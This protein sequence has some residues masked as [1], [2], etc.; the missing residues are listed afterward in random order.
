MKILSPPVGA[1]DFG[2]ALYRCRY[3]GATIN[4]AE[5]RLV[6]PILPGVRG[7]YV[8][9]PG[10]E[11]AHRASV[12]AFNAMDANCNTCAHLQRTKHAKDPAGFLFGT[13]TGPVACA[14]RSP[15]AGR[16]PGQL[17]FHPED[18]MGMPHYKPRAQFIVDDCGTLVPIGKDLL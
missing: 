18:R 10:T 12:A 11:A 8:A 7:V 2:N 3:T 1:D 6:G 17:M 14:P 4:A 16:V 9:A 13:C 15:Y 5:A